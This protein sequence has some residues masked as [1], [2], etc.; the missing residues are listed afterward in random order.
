MN[1]NSLYL[2]LFLFAFATACKAPVKHEEFT[3]GEIWTDVEGNP[4]NAHGGGIL[5]NNGKYYWFGQALKG[6]TR[7]VE[8]ITE[9]YRVKVAGVSCYS[10]ADLYNW[11]FE[12]LALEP[13]TVDSKSAI[14]STRFIDRPRVIY[15]EATQKFVMWMLISSEDYSFVSAGVAVSDKPEGPYKYHGSLQPNEQICRDMTL[16]K[17]S[18]GKA[19]Q[20][21]SSGNNA[22]IY[23]NE[24]TSDYLKTTGKYAKTFIGL[25]RKAPAM[26]KHN[27]K[28]YI[29]SSA[30][31]R[32][33]PHAASYAVADSVLGEYRI[34]GNPCTGKD[35][36][37]TYFSQSTYILPV[38]G[39]KGQYIAM[40]DKW[41]KTNLEDSRYVWLPLRFENDI[42]VI[43]WKESWKLE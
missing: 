15:N 23:I 3:P 42:M 7:K 24:L 29:L 20:I 27:S 36:D 5:Y 12:G 34:K 38:E 40:F 22:T 1:R 26:V 19:Y 10:S 30:R 2:C 14:H 17:D 6:K 32:W 28:Y 4:I 43:E 16:F 9:D 37:S 21:C 8:H 39:K 35:A 11:K 41:N 25:N 31:S 33:E 13:D 18:N